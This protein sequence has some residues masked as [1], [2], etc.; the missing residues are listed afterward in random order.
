M[1][2]KSSKKVNGEVD[3]FDFEGMNRLPSP[4]IEEVME[5]P[6]A[7]KEDLKKLKEAR[8]KKAVPF[9]LPDLGVK[10]LLAPCDIGAYMNTI[11]KIFDIAEEDNV[12]T[13]MKVN[14]NLVASCLVEPKLTVEELEEILKDGGPEVM[15]LF[16][17]CREISGMGEN[18][19]SGI[20]RAIDMAN[21]FLF[22][23]RS[24]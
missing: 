16:A 1:A 4:K 9:P 3:G 11:G 10:L 24:S 19:S 23:I 15:E 12:E 6:T 2:R 7:T 5:L 14:I 17:F 18:I 21:D 22:A 13:A 20:Q 8:L